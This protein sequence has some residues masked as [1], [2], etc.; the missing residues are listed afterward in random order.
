VVAS[1]HGPAER[2]NYVQRALDHVRGISRALGLTPTQPVE[3]VA[4]PD[5][6]AT[7]SGSVAVHLHQL[8]KGIPVFQAQ[9]CVR[10]SPDGTL[11]DTT[12]TTVSIG[13]EVQAVPTLSVQQAVLAA[14]E[15]LATPDA[16][17]VGARDPF[18]EPLPLPTVDLTGFTPSVIATFSEKPERPTVLEAGPFGDKIKASLL[19]F[20]INNTLSLT[21]E[22]TIT[23][24]EKAGQYRTLVKAETGDI[25]YCH[26]LMQSVMARGHVFHVDGSSNRQM[27]DFPRPLADYG[28]PIPSNVPAVFPDDWVGA[29]DSEGNSVFAHL[30]DHGPTIPGEDVNGQLTFDPSDSTGDD[31]KVLN[32]FY[33]NCYMHDFFYLLG[34]READG[35]FQ[36]DNLGRGGVASDRVDARAHSGAV[37]GTANMGTPMDGS[38]PEM[39]MGLVTSTNRH[40]AFDSSV[41]FHEFMHGV[42]NRLVG[43]PMDVRALDAHQSGGMGEGWGD[44]IACTIN[45]TNVVG[46]WVTQNPNGIRGFPY[47]SNFPDDFGKLGT[48]RYSGFLPDGR[49]WPH[50]IGEIWCATLLELNRRIGKLLAL[51]LVIDAL[52]LSPSNPSFLDMRD[53]VLMALEDKLSSGQLTAEEHQQAET[54]MWAVFA[55]FGMGPQAQSA[56]ATLMGIVPDFNPPSPEPIP[57][58]EHIVQVNSSPNIP[59]PDNDPSGISHILTVDKAGSIEHLSVSVDIQHTYIGDL[60]VTLTSPSGKTA[61]LHNRTGASAKDLIKTY[62]SDDHAGV[63]IFIDEEA[64]GNWMIKVSDHAGVD[65]GT[66]QKW[67][68]ILTLGQVSQLVHKELT[69]SLSIPDKDPNGVVSVMSDLAPSGTTQGIKVALDITHTYIG[70]L[71]VELIAPTGQSALLHNRKGE[72]QDNIIGTFDSL[73]TPVLSDLIGQPVAGP[74]ELRVSDHAGQDIGKLN[75][76]SLEVTLQD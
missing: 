56:G 47:D 58:P 7:S 48:G 3:F 4:D 21:W 20:S 75:K 14:A 60:L 26:Q 29:R 51:Q 57:D 6:Q 41:V 36:R 33:Y 42:T 69:P 74:W 53:A 31:Q 66:L 55:R 32:I 17:E 2:G 45:G 5:M 35:N 39:N 37:F 59:I 24:P 73:T 65:L 71:K 46:D 67:E 12:G 40:T 76:W 61:I 27:T 68:L 15:H 16:D 50:P 8:Y 43:G 62:T 72:G 25:V 23:M 10:F 1:E 13:E 54:G 9:E 49:R 44:Y 19:W 22:V 63:A 70:D 34:F 52:K 11:K 64:Q 30:G 28:L 38:N 18:G